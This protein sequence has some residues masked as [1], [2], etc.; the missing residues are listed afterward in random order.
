MN[1][2]Y[3][4]TIFS[5]DMKLPQYTADCYLLVSLPNSLNSN[6]NKS[7]PSL[8]PMN[9]SPSRYIQTRVTLGRLRTLADRSSPSPRPPIFNGPVRN[10]A[11]EVCRSAT[12]PV[13]LLADLLSPRYLSRTVGSSKGSLV[14]MA[15]CSSHGL[16]RSRP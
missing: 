15:V 8:F 7:Y 14:A 16:P 13:F 11:S 10:A 5:L 1:N 3:L 9:C 4:I 2:Q 12:F 6:V